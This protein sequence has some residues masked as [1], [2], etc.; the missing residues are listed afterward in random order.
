M[1]KC[2]PSTGHPCWMVQ[3][4]VL[5]R[6]GR[7]RAGTSVQLVMKPNIPKY[8]A[9]RSKVCVW[10]CVDYCGT[11]AI[12][13]LIILFFKNVEFFFKLKKFK[14]FL[15]SVKRLL[16]AFWKGEHSAQFLF[17]HIFFYGHPW[18]TRDYLRKDTPPFSLP[19]HLKV[20]YEY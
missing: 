3:W 13:T 10:F 17:A 9:A 4:W 2:F 15:Y 6:S 1:K 14:D 11:M 19:K 18:P 12:L 7:P 20:F 8:L 5:V 16:C